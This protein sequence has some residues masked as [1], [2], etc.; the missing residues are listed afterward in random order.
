MP[1]EARIT[2]IIPAYNAQETIA[3]AIEA[4]M[5][6]AYAGS[7][8]LV[9]VDDGSTD[10]LKMLWRVIRRCALFVRRIPVRQARAIVVPGKLAGSFFFLRMQTAVPSA[11]GLP[12]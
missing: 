8:E 1:V 10:R 5:A 2:V 9:V 6:Q 11:G 7:V 12:V 3:S 4:V